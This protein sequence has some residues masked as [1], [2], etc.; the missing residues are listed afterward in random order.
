MKTEYIVAIVI[1]FVWQAITRWFIFE[2]Y[3]SILTRIRY[4][5]Y[6]GDIGI[7]TRSFE[8]LEARL[9][10]K[11]IWVDRID[12]PCL[13]LEHLNPK[14]KFINL[15]KLILWALMFSIDLK[16]LSLKMTN[17]SWTHYVDYIKWKC[18]QAQFWLT[19]GKSIFFSAFYLFLFKSRPNCF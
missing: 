5:I 12:A 8:F 2:N 9:E 17:S 16:L 14:Q 11:L 4:P 6:Q 10:P 3:V 1:T 7:V 13:V 18:N 19:I 15:S